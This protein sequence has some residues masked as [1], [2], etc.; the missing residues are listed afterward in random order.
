MLTLPASLGSSLDLL[1]GLLHLLL[2]LSLGLQVIIQV[3]LVLHG[4]AGSRL[5]LHDLVLVLGLILGTK[6]ANLRLLS[7]LG[8]RKLVGVLLGLQAC[9][10]L[11]L[12]WV[13]LRLTL[14][15]TAWPEGEDGSGIIRWRLLVLGLD[16]PLDLLGLLEVG[17]LRVRLLRLLVDDHGRSNRLDQ[18]LV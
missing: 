11:G 14:D 6:L 2:D 18:D 12:A 7:L 8:H 9:T 17:H 10:W 16:L 15:G 1:L 5:L 13:H 3:Q 4:L